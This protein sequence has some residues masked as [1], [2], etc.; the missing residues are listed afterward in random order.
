LNFLLTAFDEH[1]QRQNLRTISRGVPTIAKPEWELLYKS[2]GVK[3]VC[4]A[5]RD[6]IF[7]P[8]SS[9]SWKAKT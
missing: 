3:P 9:P 1:G 7:D 5:M 2:S 4:L 8:I 6:I